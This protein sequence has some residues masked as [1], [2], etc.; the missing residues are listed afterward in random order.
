MLFRSDAIKGNFA[1]HTFDEGVE[2]KPADYGVVGEKKFTCTVCGYEKTEDIDALGAKDNEIKLQDGK[3]LDKTYDGSAVDVSDKFSFNGNGEVTLMFK[4]QGAEDDAY[5]ATAPKNAGEYTVKVSVRATAEWKATSK[6]F[7]FAIAKKVLT[8]TGTKVYDGNA[9][10]SATLT[11]VVEGDAVT[12]TI[13]M[14][15]KNIDATVQSVMLEGADKDNYTINIENVSVTIA[16]R[17]IKIK[18]LEVEYNGTS[19]YILVNEQASNADA[20]KY[21]FV[22][23]DYVNLRLSFNAKANAGDTQADL[24][25]ISLHGNDAEN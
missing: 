8:A 10:V 21:N 1:A 20:T 13:T 4:A 14:T 22:T 19:S 9:T 25:S 2:T 17:E 7:D 23:G 15:S 12:A 16:P 18:D 24:K 11:G 3:T 5:A 6:T